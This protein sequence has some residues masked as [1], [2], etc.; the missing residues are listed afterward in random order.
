M[1]LTVKQISSLEKIRQTDAL[2]AEELL[3]KT[4]LL[5]ERFS[6]QICIRPN[7]NTGAGLITKITV[8]SPLKDNIQVYIVKDAVMDKP[9]TDADLQLEDYITHTPGFMPDILV[10]IEEQNNSFTIGDLTRT[11]WVR[12]DVPTNCLVNNT[13]KDPT[14][15]HFRRRAGSCH[16]N[17]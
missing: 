10:P 4:V 2:P 1:N 16:C 8:D 14:R 5:G 6:Y 13:T 11:L 3:T 7:E 15:R 12:I 9:V 17:L